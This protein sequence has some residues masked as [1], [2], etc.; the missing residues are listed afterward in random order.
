MLFP[1]GGTDKIGNFARRLFSEVGAALDWAIS[2]WAVT[3][4]VLIMLILWAGKQ[5][6]VTRRYL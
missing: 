4:M 5:R 6:R 3:A 1:G 2:N